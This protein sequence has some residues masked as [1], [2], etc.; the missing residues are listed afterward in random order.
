MIVCIVQVYYVRYFF[1]RE[2]WK[3]VGE[4]PG[5]RFVLDCECQG[6]RS[7]QPSSIDSI[8]LVKVAREAKE[9]IL[10]TDNNY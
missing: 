7:R 1:S 5:R 3:P 4:D 2:G 9:S 8:F 10:I 6:L